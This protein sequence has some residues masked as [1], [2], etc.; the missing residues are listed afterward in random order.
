MA[1][2]KK[3]SQYRQGTYTPK[4]TD[5]YIGKSLPR[6]LSSWELKF[7][8]WCDDNNNVVKWSSENIVIPYLNP[9]DGKIHRYIV[10]NTIHLKEG[11]DIVKYLIEIK[12]KKQTRKPTSHGNKKKSTIIYENVEYVRNQSKWKAARGWCDKN[13]YKFQILTEDDLFR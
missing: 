13:N 7:F 4:H 11:D 9:L 3:F 8:R 1:A 5:K 6:Y 2:K 10:D 12:P